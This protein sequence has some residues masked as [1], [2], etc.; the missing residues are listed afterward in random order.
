MVARKSCIQMSPIGWEMQLSL[1]SGLHHSCETCISHTLTTC[2]LLHFA[3]I[4]M[5][6]HS[7]DI[8]GRGDD[9]NNDIN[10]RAHNFMLG[11][12]FYV[13]NNW[14]LQY[15]SSIIGWS[16]PRRNLCPI[17]CWRIDVTCNPTNE[18]PIEAALSWLQTESPRGPRNHLDWGR[19]VVGYIEKRGGAGE[20]LLF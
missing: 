12:P 8:I 10:M 18:E 11:C 17:C 5:T 9:N 4:N 15:A 1:L 16:W 7:K 20:I 3:S 6:V 19:I 14:V 2:F 13:H